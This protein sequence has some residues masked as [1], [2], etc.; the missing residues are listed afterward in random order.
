MK[1]AE[2]FNKFLE[3]YNVVLDD[4]DIRVEELT[5]ITSDSIIH[6]E[7]YISID[8]MEYNG[9]F[10]YNL[11]SWKFSIEDTLIESLVQETYNYIGYRDFIDF[12]ESNLI[13]FIL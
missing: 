11:L 9:W 8:G 13:T 2:E 7:I 1:I 5:V 6:G 12:F 10:S 3:D 4:V